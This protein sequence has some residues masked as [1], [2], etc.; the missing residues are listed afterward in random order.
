MNASMEWTD[1]TDECKAQ[2]I[3]KRNVLLEAAV[4][5]S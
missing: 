4:P 2:V 3:I 5:Y 1:G